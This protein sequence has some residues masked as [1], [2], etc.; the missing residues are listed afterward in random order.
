[1]A[2]FLEVLPPEIRERMIAL[3][4]QFLGLLQAEAPKPPGAPHLPPGEGGQRPGE[5]QS[6]A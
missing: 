5:G 1:M 6:A 4:A 2:L 3:D